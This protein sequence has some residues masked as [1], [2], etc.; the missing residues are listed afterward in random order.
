[1][2][3]N[4]DHMFS[5]NSSVLKTQTLPLKSLLNVTDTNIL[6]MCVHLMLSF[7]AVSYFCDFCF[8]RQ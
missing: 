7:F 3:P 1:M 2:L 4:G 8:Y 5:F 6:M